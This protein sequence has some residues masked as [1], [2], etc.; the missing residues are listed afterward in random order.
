MIKPRKI[1]QRLL[2]AHKGFQA[3]DGTLSAASIAYYI[4]LSFFPL[5]LVLVSG[6]ATFLEWT[7]TGQ[8]AQHAL[9]HTISQQTSPDLGK[10]VGRMLNAVQDRASA[11]GPI[12][13]LVLLASSI[14]IFG[15]LD[16]AFDRVW[17]LPSDPHATW[18]E[19]L[20]RLVFQRLKSLAML[21]GLA[22]FVIAV[23][24]TSMV[25]SALE[26]RASQTQLP[27]AH[28]VGWEL[29]LAINLAL[30]WMALVVLY[31]FVPKAEVHWVSAARGGFIAA[32]LWEVGRQGL[33]A[34][35]LHL[36]YQSAYGIIGSFIVVMLW[37]Y[38]ASLVILIG[39]GV[40]ARVGGRRRDRCQ[41]A[42]I[43]PW[44]VVKAGDRRLLMQRVDHRGGDGGGK[45]K[46]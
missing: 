9:L 27:F 35:V 43:F 40:R 26:R 13:F 12:G 5:L 21:L 39:A 44:P 17:Q 23:M 15:Q 16:A 34:Y 46:R 8:D 11:N 37:A 24:V 29:S 3:H 31:R 20:G 28:W 22:G 41:I 42:A 32:V 38:Y 1:G 4:A 14:A 25:W 30:T 7:Q 33:A 2:A 19:W 10:Q 45:H 6:L 18:R 36:N